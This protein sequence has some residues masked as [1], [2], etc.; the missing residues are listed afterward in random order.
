MESP[1]ESWAAGML[2]RQRAEKGP[3]AA[4]AHLHEGREPAVPIG[5]QRAEAAGLRQKVGCVSV[6]RTAAP[7]GLCVQRLGAPLTAHP[8]HLQGDS[9]GTCSSLQ[10]LS[11]PGR[12]QDPVT[13]MSPFPTPH[14]PPARVLAW[15]QTAPAVLRVPRSLAGAGLPCR[16]QQGHVCPSE[17]AARGSGR[18]QPVSRGTSEVGPA[19]TPA[20][21][22]SML[23]S[24]AGHAPQRATREGSHAVLPAAAASEQG[25]DIKERSHP[26][27]R[28]RP[29]QAWGRRTGGHT[30]AQ[31]SHR[32]Q[33]PPAT[34]AEVHGL[35]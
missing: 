26:S 33:P 5:C 9:R 25:I 23:G 31:P 2:H 20:R 10:K 6:C 18:T 35:P 7:M 11:Q 8:H 3:T 15:M 14:H 19:A 29:H 32:T 4:P 16:R 1:S 27:L 21:A 30:P 22:A 13:A 12:R 17:R 28:Q 24:V 34:A